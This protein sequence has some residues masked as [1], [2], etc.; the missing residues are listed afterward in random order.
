MGDDPE[1]KRSTQHNSAANGTSGNISSSSRNP[2][3]INVPP[4][5]ATDDDRATT[6]R[7]A[8]RN[9]THDK[10]NEHDINP[11]RI[12]KF[13]NRVLYR[14]NSM[15]TTA[16]QLPK[17]CLQKSNTWCLAQWCKLK[18]AVNK[19][20]RVADTPESQV[21]CQRCRKACRRL[22]EVLRVQETLAETKMELPVGAPVEQDTTDFVPTKKRPAFLCTACKHSTNCQTERNAIF[23]CKS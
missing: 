19:R 21:I 17:T 8:Q 23:V 16:T 12:Y 14:A 10:R 11:N 4:E 7:N 6:S 22:D 18:R 15:V 9:T 5:T 3:S 20:R 1:G 2:S 13:G